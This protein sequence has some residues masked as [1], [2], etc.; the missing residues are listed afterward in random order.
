MQRF[1]KEEKWIW[2][3]YSTKNFWVSHLED[4]VVVGMKIQ[5]KLVQERDQI[6][7]LRRLLHCLSKRQSLNYWLIVVPSVTFVCVTSHSPNY[8]GMISKTLND[9]F[10]GK[11]LL[12]AQAWPERSEVHWNQITGTV[13]R[14]LWRATFQGRFTSKGT[15]KRV[16]FCRILA[17]KAYALK[18]PTAFQGHLFVRQTNVERHISGGDFRSFMNECA[19]PQL[20]TLSGNQTRLLGFPFPLPWYPHKF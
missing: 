16:Q 8:F 4:K 12:A 9:L 1:V 17:S 7:W 3:W 19:S 18:V 10:P 11:H 20:K 13:R 6:L 5:T 2:I 15:D 14:P